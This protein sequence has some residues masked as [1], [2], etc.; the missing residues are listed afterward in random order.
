MK[1]RGLAPI[2]VT[3]SILFDVFARENDMERAFEM[4]GAWRAGLE[5]DEYT[6]GV[7][8]QGLRAGG[9]MKHVW[10]LFKSMSEKMLKLSNLICD[11]MIYGHSKEGSTC[12][13]PRLLLKGMS[14]NGMAPKVDSYSVSIYVLCNQGKRQEVEVLLNEMLA[15]GLR[16]NGSIYRVP[17]DAKLKGP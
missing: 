1:E 15:S 16:P 11:M 6:Y 14:Q 7:L 10:K 2:N 13:A 4:Y 9:I 8:I 5:V 3:Y 12:R 17:Y